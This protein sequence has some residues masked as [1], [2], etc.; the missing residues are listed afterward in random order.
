METTNNNP[1]AHLKQDIQVGDKTHQYFNLQD[2]K[3]ERLNKL[4]FSI[5]VLLESAIRNCDNF[6]VKEADVETILNWPETSQ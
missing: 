6:N 4:P 3:D 2:L 1:F 5:R